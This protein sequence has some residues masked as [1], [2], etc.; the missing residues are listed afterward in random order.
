M[1]THIP[2]SGAWVVAG[3]MRDDHGRRTILQ[4]QYLLDIV[5]SCTNMVQSRTKSNFRTDWKYDSRVLRQVRNEQVKLTMIKAGPQWG[6]EFCRSLR[7]NTG[8]HRGHEQPP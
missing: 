7:S 5:A 6:G 8:S 4:L 2:N 3:D 1:I